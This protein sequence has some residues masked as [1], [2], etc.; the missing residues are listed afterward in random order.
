MTKTRTSAPSPAATTRVDPSQVPLVDIVRGLT[1][2]QAWKLGGTL[3]AIVVAAVAGGKWIEGW[4]RERAIAAVV[5]PKDEKI[6]ELSGRIG[7]L[8][9]SIIVGKNEIETLGNRLADATRFIAFTNKYITY[10]SSGEEPARSIFADHV[11]MLYRESQQAELGVSMN[12]STVARTL[13]NIRAPGSRG[14]LIAAGLDPDLIDELI[15]LQTNGIQ[16]SLPNISRI[17]GYGVAPSVARVTPFN[18]QPVN[19]PTAQRVAA[20]VRKTLSGQSGQL[21][22]VVTFHVEGRDYSYTMPPEIAGLVHN[23]PDCRLR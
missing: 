2:G 10:L 4:Q 13:E 8:D 9:A 17:V 18:G 15:E 3:V 12:T 7:E 21:V 14:L 22:K 1:T 19:N 5:K 6:A 16:R 11:C 23:N 20:D